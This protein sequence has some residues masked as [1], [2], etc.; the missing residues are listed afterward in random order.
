VN[1]DG[2]PDLVTANAYSNDVSVLLG[3]GD[4]TFALTPPT[5]A[6]GLRNTPYFADF[7]GEGLPDSIVLDRSGNILLRKG[8]PGA[9]SPFTPPVILNPGRP[10][11]DLTVLRPPSGPV[12]ATADAS[13]DRSLSGPNHFVYTVSLYTLAPNGTAHRSTAF[14]TTRLPTRIAAADL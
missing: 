7:T 5:H 11:R 1:G 13:F 8:L 9:D 3:H 10:A 12:I 2:K 14:S 4:G 6:V